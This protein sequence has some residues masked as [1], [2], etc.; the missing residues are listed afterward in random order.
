VCLAS[1]TIL[2]VNYHRIRF[3][4]LVRDTA[5]S[6]SIDADDS[7]VLIYWCCLL[8]TTSTSIPTSC[9]YQFMMSTTTC[10]S[11]CCCRSTLQTT[12][13]SKI[14][15]LANHPC[16]FYGHH[17]SST[18]CCC[19]SAKQMCVIYEVS[20]TSFITIQHYWCADLRTWYR[21]IYSCVKFMLYC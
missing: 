18:P 16:I 12:V 21:L 17:R 11:V 9:C 5:S 8:P 10:A 1:G 3:L 20:T 4:I 13:A 15:T 7:V 14:P 19:D 2:F 6:S